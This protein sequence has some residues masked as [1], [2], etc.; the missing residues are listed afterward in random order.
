VPRKVCALPVITVKERTIPTKNSCANA[1]HQLR[2]FLIGFSPLTLICL[3]C[4][5][6]S[7]KELAGR[8]KQSNEKFGSNF[9]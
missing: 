9:P 5:L 1:R 4:R 8:I 6:S 7:F 2:G 3:S